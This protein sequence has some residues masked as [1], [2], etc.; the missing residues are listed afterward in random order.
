MLGFAKRFGGTV[1]RR[2]TLRGL[3]ALRAQLSALGLGGYQ[4]LDGSFVEDVERLQ[5][6][7]PGD[8][9]VVTFVAL[10][11]ATNQRRLLQAAPAV[12]NSAQA[13][14]TYRVD[15]YF[16]PTD[17]VLGE[18]QARHVAYWCSM[19]SHQR[20]TSRWKGFVTVP[21]SSNDP[22]ANSW[23]DQQDAA[24]AAAQGATQGGT[25]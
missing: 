19:W 20:V 4:W 13:K 18:A 23:L 21:L 8:V 16:V 5:S 9:D 17:V 12:F 3:L 1:E 6:R 10:G 11:D 2:K 22:D 25:P 15:H 24:Q 14:S 7:P